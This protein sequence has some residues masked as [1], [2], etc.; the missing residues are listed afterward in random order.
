MYCTSTST[1]EGAS[2]ALRGP[3]R[4]RRSRHLPQQSAQ[5][6]SRWH[7][8]GRCARSRRQVL[9]AGRHSEPDSHDQLARERSRRAHQDHSP[10][11]GQ[12][13][14]AGSPSTE[15]REVR[16]S[17]LEELE[18]D[19]QHSAWKCVGR[20]APRAPKTQVARIDG[21]HGSPCGYMT[22]GVERTRG[23][24]PVR[25]HMATSTSNVRGYLSRSSFAANLE[26]IDEDRCDHVPVVSHLR[27][28][29][30]SV[31]RDPHAVRP[32]S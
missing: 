23:Q 31:L 13:S 2:S 4:S 15:Y 16:L 17:Q 30:A 20:A 32:S 3:P 29:S 26:R 27:G 14:A 10:S 1:S 22:S 12:A 18:D 5:P 9:V 24:R 6:Q 28:R 11:D 8:V 7:P 25:P 19:G 21:N